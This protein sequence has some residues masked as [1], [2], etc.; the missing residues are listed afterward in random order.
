MFDRYPDAGGFLPTGHPLFGPPLASLALVGV[1]YVVARGWR[2][3]RLGVLGDLVLWVGLLGVAATVETTPNYLRAVGML[4]SLC[5]V[6]AL[7]VLDV[8]DRCRVASGSTGPIGQC[9]RGPVPA[10]D[11]GRRY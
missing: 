2:D 6:L 4:P 8:M 11:R 1:F 9:S 10:V 5:C 3:A 7:L